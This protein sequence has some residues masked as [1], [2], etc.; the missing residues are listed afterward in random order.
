VNTIK[1]NEANRRRMLVAT[2]VGFISAIG[3]I[4]LVAYTAVPSRPESAAA[5]QPEGGKEVRGGASSRV[6]TAG[7]LQTKPADH[8]LVLTLGDVL[9]TSGRED[10]KPI[11][12]GNLKKLVNFLGQYPDRKVA[13]H[14]YTDSRGSEEYNQGL[15]ERRANSVKTYLA[16][17]GID[18]TRLFASG[19][20]Q[21]DPVAGNDSEAGRQRNRRVEVI[22]SNPPVVL[23]QRD[24]PAK[25]IVLLMLLQSVSGSPGR[26]L[27]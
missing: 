19:M 23:T 26:P 2:A 9:F 10:L 7:L 15:S 11:A 4:L 21:T 13:I 1:H 3:F 5:A 18:S 24:R 17:Q 12:M 25:M 16:A 6:G 20:G 27:L 14:G 8:E 22:I